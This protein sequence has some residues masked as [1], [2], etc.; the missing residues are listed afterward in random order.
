[1]KRVI[2]CGIAAV[3]VGAAVAGGM[4][5]AQQA[6]PAADTILLNGKIITVDDRFT[7]AQAV[8]VR[9]DRFVA[10]GTNQE[11]ARLAGPNTRRIDLR[12]RAVVPGLI[13]NHAHFQEEGAYWTLELRLD[14]V[15]SRRQAL[16][17]I[18]AKAK[19]KGPGEWVFNLGGW[20]PDQFADDPRPFTRDELDK[21]APDNPVFLQFS[22]A[23]TFLNS[24]AIEMIGLEKMN[25][26]WI[27]RD[28]AG[29][30][31]GVIGPAGNGPV[32]KLAN[33]LDAP[34]GQRA[35]LPRDVVVKSSLA[36]LR[37][38]N[39]AGLTAS[40]G[41]CT[42]DDLYR[43]FQRDGRL[44]MRF[45]CMQSAP[46]G[47]RGAGALDKQI[48]NLRALKWFD[49]DEWQDH[50]SYGEN[51]PGGGGDNL[52]AATQQPVPAEQW[53]TFGRFAREV[54]K[55]GIQALLH[56]QTDVAVEGKLQQLE[57]MQREGTSIR[58][59]RW[60][61][62]HMEGVTPAQVE[63]MKRLNMFIAV[64][65]REIVTGGLLER[66][67]GQKALTMPPLREIHES[68]IMW[69]LGTDAFE[70][71]QYRPFQTMYWAVT[72]KMVGGKVVNTSTVSRE[73]ALIA[74]TRNNAYLFFR[75]ND[76]G[77]IQSGRL[78]DLVVID[79]DYLT[80]PAEQ[81]KDIRPVMTMV[82]GRIV[83]E[84]GAAG[85]R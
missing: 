24:K 47:G 33:F 80:V 65:P 46:G 3:A 6:P 76:L 29:R 11:V 73:A 10:V 38:L 43:E 19:E 30:A 84:A 62:M 21:Y 28:A 17:M 50:I 82:G 1:M 13:D 67:H 57:R 8:A 74:Y 58:P 32:R 70:V 56:T 45:F 41:D 44:T 7:I 9:G 23:E 59:L 5:G 31:T 26:P 34:N 83:Y 16:E 81:I 66:V 75:E 52:Y 53:E 51:F 60:G 49:G 61:F 12:G 55:A 18:R 85:T 77:S 40:G 39:A 15:D 71:N 35:N 36:M 79:R 54:A 25:E 64:H 14:G 20:S 42:W 48:A 37:D 68:G 63:R 22:R 4:V 78:A 69:G 72:G 27:M 2:R